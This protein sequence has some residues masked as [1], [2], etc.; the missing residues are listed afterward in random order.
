MVDFSTLSYG[1]YIYPVEAT[2]LGL[3]IALSSIS[4]VPIVAIYKVCQLTGPIKEVSLV[5]FAG[6][7]YVLIFNSSYLL[8]Y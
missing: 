1:D 4:M 8:A 6:S 5:D 7:F 2:V 3:F